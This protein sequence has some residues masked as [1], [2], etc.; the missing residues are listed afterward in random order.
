MA[1]CFKENFSDNRV[2]YFYDCRRF[3][4]FLGSIQRFYK[5]KSTQNDTRIEDGSLYGVLIEEEM[6]YASA[7]V[8]SKCCLHI[9]LGKNQQSTDHLVGI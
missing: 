1:S 2:A 9:I 5:K 7:S 3:N 6:R 4:N 8:L